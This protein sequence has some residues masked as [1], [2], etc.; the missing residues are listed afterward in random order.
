MILKMVIVYVVYASVGPVNLGGVVILPE[1]MVCAAPP[2]MI[3]QVIP[4]TEYLVGTVGQGG[5]GY[6]AGFAT[7]ALNTSALLNETLTM[8]HCKHTMSKK[9]CKLHNVH[10]TVNT[11]HNTLHT[12][13]RT[14]H[15]AHITVQA[16]LNL[17]PA[18]R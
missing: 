18:A 9:Y 1:R 11:A 14:L 5:E 4:T 10:R 8:A 16:H 12:T 3:L 6:M 13:K 2:R 7:A 17:L 15:T